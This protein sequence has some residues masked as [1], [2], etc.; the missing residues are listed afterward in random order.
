MY[1]NR[2]LSLDEQEQY[3]AALAYSEKALAILK[4]MFK[5]RPKELE[6]FLEDNRQIRGKL[7]R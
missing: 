6:P 7:G 4:V 1:N 5:D 2:A 3:E